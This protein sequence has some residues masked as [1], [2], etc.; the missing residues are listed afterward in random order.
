MITEEEFWDFIGSHIK[1]EDCIVAKCNKSPKCEFGYACGSTLWSFYSHISK[2]QREE[3][4]KKLKEVL[5]G[6][7]ETT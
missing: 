5:D 3:S 6:E 1:C 4:I 7:M 2:V